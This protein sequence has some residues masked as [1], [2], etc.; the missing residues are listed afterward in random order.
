VI[1]QLRYIVAL[2][3]VLAHA[4]TLRPKGRGINPVAIKK[5]LTSWCTG[6]G[7]TARHAGDHRVEPVEKDL[8][9]T[10]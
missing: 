10:E 1:Q 8:D 2:M 9:A 7:K 4:S 5:H 3:N 6:R